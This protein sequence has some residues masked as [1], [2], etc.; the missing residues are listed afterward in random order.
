MRVVIVEI[1]ANTTSHISV[2]GSS[3]CKSVKNCPICHMIV[4]PRT[5]EVDH[6]S[7]RLAFVIIEM[8]A[9]IRQVA[10]IETFHLF[11]KFFFVKL[12]P[13]LLYSGQLGAQ[14]VNPN[15]ELR[16]GLPGERFHSVT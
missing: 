6:K 7:R 8:P 11:I 5:N 2:N 10:I 3:V 4:R 15:Q 16:N 12:Q 1:C 9:L 13:L 14:T